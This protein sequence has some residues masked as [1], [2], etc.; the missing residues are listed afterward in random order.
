MRKSHSL[1][2]TLESL[3]GNELRKISDIILNMLQNMDCEET[4]ASTPEVCPK[5]NC[6]NLAKFGKDKHGKQRY[7]CNGCHSTFISTSFSVVSYSRFDLTIWKR[8]IELLLMGAPLAKCA[9]VCGISVKTAFHWRH[10]ILY[11]LQKDQNNRVL[12]GIVELDE[13]YV[14]ISY[15]GNHSKSSHF[16]MPR[17]AYKRGSDNKAQIGSK[18][19]V[20]C[21]IERNGQTYGEVL[22][23]GQPTTAMLSHAFNNR[24]LTDSIVLSDK[25]SSIGYYFNN[26]TTIELIQLE[27]HTVVKGKYG[28]PEVRGAMHIQTVNNLHYRIRSFLRRYNGV[29][30]KYLN[31]YLA[32]F[33]WVENHNTLEDNTPEKD[34]LNHIT[35]ANTHINRNS[36]AL[37]PPIPQVA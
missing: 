16:V 9:E 20:M 31:H 2:N 30:T 25:S 37:M 12:A 17:K 33:I 18:A 26:F 29:A 11:A 7:R 36:F 21:A 35:Q 27:A 14:P 22:G 15:K 6:S 23:K 13:M 3:D 8:Y 19:C 4:G 1:I 34:V 24:I 28:P 5:C 32:L 10:K